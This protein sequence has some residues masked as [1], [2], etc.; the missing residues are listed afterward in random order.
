M[1]TAQ[2]PLDVSTAPTTP[3]IAMAGSAGSEGLLNESA[4]AVRSVA[5]T[6]NAGLATTSISSD[7]QLDVRGVGSMGNE[8]GHGA[9][10]SIIVSLSESNV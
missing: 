3:V 4:T 9:W 1:A 10:S 7:V 5:E 8:G 2:Q 6:A